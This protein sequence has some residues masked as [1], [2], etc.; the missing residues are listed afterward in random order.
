MYY[1]VRSS[2]FYCLTNAFSEAKQPTVE[3]LTSAHT[4]SSEY[5]TTAEGNSVTH[6]IRMFDLA[7]FLT[8]VTVHYFWETV[9]S[10]IGA[11]AK[12]T[13]LQH[14]D[15]VGNAAA[16]AVEDKG[17]VWYIPDPT[18]QYNHPDH[19]THFLWFWSGFFYLSRSSYSQYL[20]VKCFRQAQKVPRIQ[21]PPFWQ[22]CLFSFLP[23]RQ[24]YRG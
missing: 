24:Y 20:P 9:Q 16:V 5:P 18:T 22:Q 19:L 3:V 1:R 13:A 23:A 7:P 2:V 10:T 4:A 14:P 15:A 8:T 21:V 17:D 6:G 12:P 11:P